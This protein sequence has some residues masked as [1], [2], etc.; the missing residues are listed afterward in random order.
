[1][2]LLG[3]VA[4]LE[5]RSDG[6]D[7]ILELSHQTATQLRESAR[8]EMIVKTNFQRVLAAQDEVGGRRAV[9]DASVDK[10]LEG[11]T[12]NLYLNALQRLAEAQN[13]YFISLSETIDVSELGEA[14]ERQKQQWLA[15][16]RL[17]VAISGRDSTL[18]AWEVVRARRKEN[19]QNATI[20]AEAQAR[21]QYFAFQAI[22]D[23]AQKEYMKGI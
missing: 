19:G 20:Q 10:R 22:V 16:E 5:R 11:D 18:R 12:I 17:D 23:R 21:T 4:Q 15:H 14:A 7:E 3:V 13:E 8:R 9:W 6:S 1:L 2:R